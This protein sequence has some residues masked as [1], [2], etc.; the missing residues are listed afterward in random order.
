[1]HA[2]VIKR[3][4]VIDVDT[5]C[6]RAIKLNVNQY[7]VSLRVG[8]VRFGN[9]IG[10]TPC[11]VDLTKGQGSWIKHISTMCS[12]LAFSLYVAAGHNELQHLN[13]WY[14][15]R[16]KEN[17]RQHPITKGEPALRSNR[18]RRAKPVFSRRGP[19][20]VIAWTTGS[21]VLS[22]LIQQSM[23][24]DD[25]SEK[26]DYKAVHVLLFCARLLCQ[27]FEQH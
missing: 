27:A 12:V 7:G 26:H 1:M 25:A 19:M 24:T 20:S 8:D 10:A 22:C 11:S 9:R 5:S 23:T 13:I 17:F 2:A 15:E 3:R 16:W 4:I 18:I 21:D 14:I 6:N